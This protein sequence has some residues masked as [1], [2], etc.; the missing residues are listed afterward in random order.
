MGWVLCKGDYYWNAACGLVMW[1]HPMEAFVM[2]LVQRLVRSRSIV[3]CDV[4]SVVKD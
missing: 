1:V 3:R 4:L 2:G